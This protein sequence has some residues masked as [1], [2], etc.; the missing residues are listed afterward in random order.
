[1]VLELGKLIDPSMNSAYEFP[2][3]VYF[4]DAS[5]YEVT[6]VEALNGMSSYIGEN[7]MIVKK[8][9]YFYLRV[10][11]VHNTSNY[12]VTVQTW[13]LEAS[14]TL[15]IQFP[16]RLL[17][18]ESP[19][20]YLVSI[21]FDIFQFDLSMFI[22]NANAYDIIFDPVGALS[23]MQ[24]EEKVVIY[25]DILNISGSGLGMKYKILIAGVNEVGRTDLL[26]FDVTESSKIYIPSLTDTRF[27]N[28]YFVEKNRQFTWNIQN[29]TSATSPSTNL[30]DASLTTFFVFDPFTLPGN[31]YSGT[32]TTNNIKCVHSMI[33]CL[34]GKIVCNAYAYDIRP[35]F[36]PKTLTVVGSNDD[37]TFIHLKTFTSLENK[38][39]EIKWNN[40]DLYFSYYILFTAAHANHI[41]L[42]SNRFVTSL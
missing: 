12:S 6:S 13:Q 16:P 10:T 11:I 42:T 4:Q 27:G 18:P 26:T 29:S 34:T 33:R 9:G 37:T 31:G 17:F 3:H 32:R 39:Q 1:V 21:G 14:S 38:S 22:Q 23:T 7:I 30:F 40:S 24:K 20:L 8:D 15:Y 41:E 19:R 36:G 35:L 25:D 5:S 28:W 2:L